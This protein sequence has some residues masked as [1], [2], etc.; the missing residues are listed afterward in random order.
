MI[1]VDWGVYDWDE[2][3]RFVISN[4]WNMMAMID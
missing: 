2:D 1:I 3:Y 4:D